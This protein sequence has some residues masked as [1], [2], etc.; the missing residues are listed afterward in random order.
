MRKLANL[1]SNIGSQ[2]QQKPVKIHLHY[3]ITQLIKVNKANEYLRTNL[4]ITMAVMEQ[5]RWNF[6]LVQEFCVT[7]YEQEIQDG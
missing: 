4:Q 3:L 7:T 5:N 1:C 2:T 6:I